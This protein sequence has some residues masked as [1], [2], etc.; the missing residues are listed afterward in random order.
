MESSIAGKLRIYT[1][2]EQLRVVLPY[3]SVLFL[4]CFSLH[5]SS[6]STQSLYDNHNCKSGKYKSNCPVC[7]EY[8]FSSRSASHEMPCG[9]A[10]HWDC[11]RQ[12]AAHDSRCPVCKK[13][14]ETK[15]RM[16]PAWRAMAAGIAMQPLPP[17]LARVV[18]ITCNDCEE[19]HSG[20]AWH[21]LGVQCRSCSS[22][23]TVVDRLVLSGEEAYRYLQDNNQLPAAVPLPPPPLPLPTPS[24][25]TT[26]ADAAGSSTSSSRNHHGVTTAATAAATPRRTSADGGAPIHPQPRRRQRRINRRR[27]L[28]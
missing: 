18:D 14:A 13:T 7:Q 25:T 11:F 19:A 26:A 1:C 24:A 20:R 12:L 8:L 17:E 21:F 2:M 5:Q 15:D 10:I 6:S 27:S 22:F 4:S 16:M 28:L 23:N 3:Q 9:H